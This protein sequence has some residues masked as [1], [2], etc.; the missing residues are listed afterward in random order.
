MPPLSKYIDLHCE[1]LQDGLFEEPINTLSNLT[2]FL[3]AYL[4]Y[5]NFKGS[6]MPSLAKFFVLIISII[7]LGSI[8]F[9]TTAR[10][11]GALTDSIPIAIFALVYVFSCGRHILNMR[12]FGGFVLI[13]AFIATY[14]GVKFLYLG[15]THGR[16][17]DGW[18]SM[19][20][21]VYFMFLLTLF[22]FITRNK[23]ALNFLKISLI[24]ALAVFFRTIDLHLCSEFHIGTHFLWH[25]LAAGMIYLMVSEVLKNHHRLNLEV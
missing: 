23:S 13:G 11:W 25:M 16:M 8:T 3:V 2:F 24:A 5:Q 1:R 6:K 7:G 21:A 10:M 20:P 14:S 12:W 15:S 22:M 4:I 17:P 18:V 9:H 19:I